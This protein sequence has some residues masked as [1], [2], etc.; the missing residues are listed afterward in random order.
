MT[1]N[2]QTITWFLVAVILSCGIWFASNF[3]DVSFTMS[4][5]L[6]NWAFDWAL[7]DVF[8]VEWVNGSLNENYWLM[9]RYHLPI[10]DAYMASLPAVLI[11]FGLMLLGVGVLVGLWIGEDRSRFVG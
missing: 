11:P 2:R 7:S 1:K 10:Q 8:G 3:H 6:G 5:H 9:I 4:P